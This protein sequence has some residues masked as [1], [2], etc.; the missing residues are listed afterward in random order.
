MKATDILREEHEV[1]LRGLEVLR[2]MAH[3]GLPP[4]DDGADLIAFIRE[5]SDGAH[6]H[7]E[8][9]LLFPAMARG[10][11]P[12][13]GGPI[14]VMLSEHVE[15]RRLVGEAE[16]ALVGGD[17]T[18]FARAAM[19][20]VELLQAH[21]QKENEILFRMAEQ[22]ISGEAADAL[23]AEFDAALEAQAELRRAHVAKLEALEAKYG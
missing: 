1:I 2:A 13:E 19:G 7:K 8:E 4:D 17:A 16:A 9:G 3:G 11:M 5:F 14:P 23:G 21:I 6:H 20:F 12:T 18:A 22:V 10:G 15:G